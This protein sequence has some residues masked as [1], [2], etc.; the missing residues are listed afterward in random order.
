[1][2]KPRRLHRTP[3]MKLPSWR[4]FITSAGLVVVGSAAV[5]ALLVTQDK[6]GAVSSTSQ[7]LIQPF[8]TWVQELSTP[9]L[10]SYR[11][12][13][14]QPLEE[15]QTYSAAVA[16]ETIAQI[17][18][19]SEVASASANNTLE[20]FARLLTLEIEDRG[21]LSVSNSQEILDSLTTNPPQKVEILS[22]FAPNR[23]RFSLSDELSQEESITNTALT[24]L[25][26]AT[27]SAMLEGVPGTI[28]TIILASEFPSEQLAPSAPTQAS[29][30]APTYTGEDLW[31]AVQTYRRAHGLPEFQQSN[32]LCTVASIRVNEQL[33]LGRLD[34]HDGFDARADQFFEDNPT[35][36]SINENLA[37][38]YETAVQ[39]VEWGWD[40]SLGH[41]ALIQS[42]EFPYACTAANAGFA[43]LITGK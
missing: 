25:G 22:L 1:M 13:S 9:H 19:E 29:T 40:Q 36:T 18:L 34:N 21:E 20:K 10:A 23:G 17:R 37:A 30:R 8:Q 14:G 43:V 42:R 28:L 12:S 2:R 39:A 35:W 7:Q 5:F 15:K 31:S 38:G 41:K 3:I 32:Q 33:A 6:I 16:S 11:N 4:S 27:R 26:V 24:E